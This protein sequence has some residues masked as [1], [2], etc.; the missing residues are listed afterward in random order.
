MKSVDRRAS[1]RVNAVEKSNAIQ[2]LWVIIALNCWI[3]K[4]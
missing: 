1:K 2:K 3:G 4:A